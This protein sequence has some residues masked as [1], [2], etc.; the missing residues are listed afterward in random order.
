M[1]NCHCPTRENIKPSEE[2]GSVF[3]IIGTTK[4]GSD[5]TEILL[6]HALSTYKTGTIWCHYGVQNQGLPWDYPGR[7]VR[8]QYKSI[9]LQ[10]ICLSV[11]VRWNF[12]APRWIIAIMYCGNGIPWQKPY[13]EWFAQKDR[14]KLSWQMA[15]ALCFLLNTST[16]ALSAASS[17]SVSCHHPRERGWPHPFTLPDTELLLPEHGRR[18]APILFIFL[19]LADHSMTEPTYPVSILCQGEDIYPGWK[20]IKVFRCGKVSGN[21]L[22]NY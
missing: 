8:W 17:Y 10:R 3:I 13:W 2:E 18:A 11:H 21:T 22:W 1:R 20:F 15:P 5:S 16:L 6:A 7:R 19:V 4:L 14:A 12:P 9:L